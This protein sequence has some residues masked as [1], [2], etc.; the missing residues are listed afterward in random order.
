MTRETAIRTGKAQTMN[1]CVFTGMPNG[2]GAHL[3]PAGYY[4]QLSDIPENIFMINRRHHSW[5]G[6]PCFD[7][8]QV[9]GVDI[10]RPV[11][12][13]LWML[14][15]MVIDDLRHLVWKK[16]RFLRAWCEIRR[17][18]V[19]VVEKPSDIESMMYAERLS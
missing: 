2:D 6:K 5:R 11:S 14:E 18:G 10:V 16:L 17:I 3:Y 12:E 13:R 9:D 1:L 8:K 19:P 7:F 15:N 4:P